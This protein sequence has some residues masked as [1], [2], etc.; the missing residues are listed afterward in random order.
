MFLCTLISINTT[1]NTEE[2]ILSHKGQE[3]NWVD[4][5][6]LSKGMQRFEDVAV[7]FVPTFLILQRLVHEKVR[8]AAFENTQ[9]PISLL[10]SRHNTFKPNNPY[11]KSKSVISSPALC[12]LLWHLSRHPFLAW[13]SLP[14]AGT[15]WLHHVHTDNKPI[16]SVRTVQ[17]GRLGEFRS[18][19]TSE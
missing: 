11:S 1:C 18:F 3:F 5:S 17:W 7:F 8:Q 15:L 9:H 10:V 4:F 12:W 13:G 2:E 14:A 6:S 16:P 19:N